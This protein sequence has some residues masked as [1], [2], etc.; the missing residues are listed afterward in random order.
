VTATGGAGAGVSPSEGWPP[1]R[2]H[3]IGG[4]ERQRRSG[5]GCRGGI[6][7]GRGEARDEAAELEVAEQL[8]DRGAVVGAAAGAVEVERDREI[9]D[10]PRHLAAVEHLL[11]VRLDR[12]AQLWGERPDGGVHALDRLVRGD[13]PCRGLLADAGNAGNVVGGV[14]LERLEVDNLVRPEAVAGHDLR[15]VVDHGV[16][17]ALAGGHDLRA[18][19]DELE[20][21]EV[22][23]QDERIEVQRLGLPG[24]RADNVVG[25]ESGK[26]VHRDAQLVEELLAPLELRAQLIRHRLPG[27]LVRRIA[28]VTERRRGQVE[29][30][31]DVDRRDLLDDLEEDRGEPEDRIHQLALRRG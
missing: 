3:R 22:T 7:V 15:F 4:E 16:L 18:R 20:G 2:G 6:P 12:R 28:L 11:V 8:D 10:D 31:G 19:R 30:R 21:V 26:R 5:R 9:G 24:E 1:G 23:R 25:L 29:A 27:G 13:E 17:K 14:A